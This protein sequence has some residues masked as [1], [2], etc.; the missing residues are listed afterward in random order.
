MGGLLARLS[1]VGPEASFYKGT[2][3]KKI[4]ILNKLVDFSYLY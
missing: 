4:Y 2:K 1:T 3:K